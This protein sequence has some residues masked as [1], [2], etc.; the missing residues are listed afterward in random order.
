MFFKEKKLSVVLLVIFSNFFLF[1]FSQTNDGMIIWEEGKLLDW[2]FFLVDSSNSIKLSAVTASGIF[3]DSKTK[4]DTL[5]ITVTAKFDPLKSRVKKG[6]Q[7]SK[8]LKHEQLHFDISEL[9]ARKLRQYLLKQ[10]LSKKELNSFLK[11]AID[12]NNQFM[13]HFQDKYDLET[14]HGKARGKQLEWEKRISIELR[15]L[16]AYTNTEVKLLLKVGN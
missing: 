7:N 2:N 5:W 1:S 6:A 16:E 3:L 15:A 4:K 12:A 11:N 13:N 14:E 10:K 8:L 9:F